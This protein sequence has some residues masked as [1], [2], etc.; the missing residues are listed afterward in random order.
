[1]QQMHTMTLNHRSVTFQKGKTILEICQDEN[2]P[3]PAMCNNN[4]EEQY[5]CCRLCMVEVSGI[6]K[7]MA[8]CT[9]YAKKGMHVLTESP[10][11]ARLRKTIIELLLSNHPGNCTCCVA[12]GNCDLEKIARVYNADIKKYSRRLS[13]VPI[14]KENPL[15]NYQPGKCIV[16]GRCTRICNEVTLTKNTKITSGN[17]STMTNTGLTVQYSYE[18][19]QSCLQCVSICITGALSEKKPE[20]SYRSQPQGPLQLHQK[21][22]FF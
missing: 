1:M 11:L 4:T 14:K 6:P 20:G 5:D 17:F 9:T 13:S 2:V 22:H 12:T 19:C 3:I 16:C 7:P 10:R 21:H 18:S 15:L 8:S